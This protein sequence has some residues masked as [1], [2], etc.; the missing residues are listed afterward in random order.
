MSGV[1]LGGGAVA[2]RSL[3]CLLSLGL[4][5]TLVG[6]SSKPSRVQAPDLDPR[7]VAKRAIQRYDQDGDAK[8]TGEELSPA[9]KALLETADQDGDGA[10]S[11]AE[12]VDRLK[13]HVES[14]IGLHDVGGT[15]L[16]DGRPLPDAVVRF[17]PDPVLEGIVE[18]ASGRTDMGGFV[19]LEIEG[20]DL[21]GVQPGFYRVEVSRTDANNREIVPSRYNVDSELGQEV[22][23][24]ALRNGLRIELTSR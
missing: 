16:L 6:C 10:L 3:L 12:I 20:N 17:L 19:E 18:P 22:G 1:L 4:L 2:H 15:V 21:P 5:S 24:D 7:G 13:A 23:A 8:L 11:Q 9:L 14:R